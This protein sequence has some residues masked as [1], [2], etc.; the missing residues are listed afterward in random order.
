[1]QAPLSDRLFSEF[2]G[3]FALVFCGVGAIVADQLFGGLGN[4]GI[5]LVFG[6]VVMVMI[7][8]VGDI[9]GA[10]FNPAVSFGFF[11]SRRFPA[12]EFVIYSVVQITASVF[13]VVLLRFLLSDFAAND[14]NFGVTRSSIGVWQGC[15]LE[16]IITFF[17][18]FVIL[19]VA[20]GAKETGMMAGLAI[21]A[22]VALA[23]AFA[24]P[25]TNASMNPARSIGPALVALDWSQLWLYSIAPM[26]GAA[27]A[28]YSCKWTAFDGCCEATV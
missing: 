15:V 7:Y 3:T 20:T 14:I 28:V 13:A 2:I 18:M 10:H 26:I 12:K 21:G 11:L 8:A 4:M 16:I 1:M 6:L 23:A 19:R 22:T 17:L 27:L 5:A 25:L 24:G 9:S